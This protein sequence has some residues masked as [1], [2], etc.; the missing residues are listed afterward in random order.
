MVTR[1]LYKKRQGFI[2]I[3]GAISSV[4]TTYT[5]LKQ[6]TT[7]LDVAAWAKDVTITYPEGPV[8]KV[9]FMGE[10]SNSFQNQDL[11]EQSWGTAKITG[12][13]VFSPVDTDAS[14]AAYMSGS[15]TAITSGE[16]RYQFGSS[17][18]VSL[19]GSKSIVFGLGASRTLLNGDYDGG[20][21]ITVDSTAGFPNSGYLIVDDDTD[22]EYTG[23]TSTTFTGVTN[24]SAQD[25]DD[26][27]VSK[28]TN[29]ILTAFNNAK[30]TKIGDVTLEGNTYTC[31]FEAVC[32]CKDFYEEVNTV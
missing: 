29:M 20:A 24:G 17:A 7:P 11:E 4:V 13:L 3:A 16:T 26:V 5:V 10:D 9:D 18:A 31:P 12:T 1:T 2:W 21:T 27:V 14:I 30:V 32:L 19:R 8:E 23:K 15:G 22:I 28:A 25:D 6:M